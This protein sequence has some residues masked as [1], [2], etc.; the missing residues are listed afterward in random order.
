MNCISEEQLHRHGFRQLKMRAIIQRVS[1]AKVEVEGKVVGQIQTGLLVYLGVGT[2]DSEKEASF[3]AD[4]LPNLRIFPDK[5]K[6]M[7]KNLL[8]IGGS[9][10]LISNFTLYG[11]CKKG[12][13]PGF[14]AAAEPVIAEKLY[15]KVAEL[16]SKQGITIETGLFGQ[17][18]QVSSTNDGPVTFFLQS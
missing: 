14:D 5:S 12:R 4:K 16:I 2:E 1:Q 17:Y 7:N 11:D 8:D 9:I 13:R 18:M 3:F 15:K 6:K 10:L